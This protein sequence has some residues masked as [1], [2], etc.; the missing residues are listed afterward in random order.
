MFLPSLLHSHHALLSRYK[1]RSNAVSNLRIHRQ[2]CSYCLNIKLQ[3]VL[4]WKSIS[5]NTC[6]FSLVNHKQ[7]LNNETM[8]T[9]ARFRE[10]MQTVVS[11]T[12]YGH[13]TSKT[14]AKTETGANYKIA[15]FKQSSG[16]SSK[17]F[18][19]VCAL[20]NQNF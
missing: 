1:K 7:N 14:E 16:E 3:I 11:S 18:F 6:I 13:N 5:H 8:K 4:F 20:F 9:K 10:R 2:F 19:S 12:C 17:H 15:S